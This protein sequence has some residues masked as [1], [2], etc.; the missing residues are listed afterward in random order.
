MEGPHMKGKL[1]E[2]I[3]IVGGNIADKAELSSRNIDT[4]VNAANPTLMGSN[5]GVDG[6]IHKSIDTIQGVPGCFKNQIYNELHTEDKGDNYIRCQRGEAVLT[7]GYGLCKYVIHVVGAKYDGNEGRIKECS[8]SAIRTL[9]SCYYSIVKLVKEHTDIHNIAIP[10]ISSGEYEIPFQTAVGIAIASV[11]NTLVEWKRQDP[12]I[13]EMSVLE[14]IYFFI[15]DE[16]CTNVKE[17]LQSAIMILQ[18]YRPI[19]DEEKRAVFQSSWGAHLHDW[20][21][22]IKYDE[23]RGYFSGAKLVREFLMSIRLLFLPSMVL[24]DWIG[25]K[26]WEKRRQFV[27]RYAIFKAL[28]PVIFYLLTSCKGIT[29]C[30]VMKNVIF[31]C[32]IIYHD[33]GVE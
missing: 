3:S 25:G 12:E 8:S 14:K 11:Y 18:D 20:K 15:Y 6:A 29:V 9:E 33:V 28:L 24:K 19:M 22:I 26:N 7:S 23:A 16:D 5:Q 27:E 4:I 2:Y 31:P 30:P 17:K 13:F 21:E 1:S 10:I 32:I